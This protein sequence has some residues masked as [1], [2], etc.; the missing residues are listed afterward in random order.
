MAY[1]MI[2]HGNLVERIEKL[3]EQIYYDYVEAG[4]DHLEFL[5][6]MDSALPFYEKLKDALNR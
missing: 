4:H 1:V 6:I 2:L 5:V 3:G